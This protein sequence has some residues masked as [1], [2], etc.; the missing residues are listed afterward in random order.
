MD[1]DVG[2]G[3]GRV[4]NW[5]QGRLTS[6]TRGHRDEYMHGSP[7]PRVGSLSEGLC[8]RPEGSTGSATGT[9]LWVRRPETG[10][11]GTK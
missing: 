4:P 1:S 8:V 6:S 5:T 2:S 3:V 7:S 11:P 10:M 9:V